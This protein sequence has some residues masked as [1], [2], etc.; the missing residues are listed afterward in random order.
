MRQ[1][2][3]GRARFLGLVAKTFIAKII[4][5]IWAALCVWYLGLSQIVPKELSEKVPK[6]YE[7]VAMTTG[8]FHWSVWAASGIFLIAVAAIEAGYRIYVDNNEL[9]KEIANRIDDKALSDALNNVFN[10]ASELCSVTINNEYT[11][12]NWESDINIFVDDVLKSL[13][14]AITELE[15]STLINSPM[16]IQ[17]AFPSRK[18]KKEIYLQHYIHYFR[19]RLLKLI[20]RKF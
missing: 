13:S 10:R 6:L 17:L 11:E 16:G 15:M 14:W 4:L 1:Q 3:W 7:F 8:F 12:S 18:T 9:K 20:E 2:I 5:P 19:E